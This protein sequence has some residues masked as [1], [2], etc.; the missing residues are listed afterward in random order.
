MNFD[1]TRTSIT[2]N[3][4]SNSN[5]DIGKKLVRLREL[6]KYVKDKLT[7]EH[8]KSKHQYN[9]RHRPHSFEVNDYV[10]VKNHALSSSAKDF[11]A[12]LGNKFCGPYKIS[13][14]LG[15]NT[16]ELVDDSN[17]LKGVWHVSQL[18]PDKTLD[19]DKSSV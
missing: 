13:K 14:K 18:K 2:D 8:E 15:V 6:R 3:G 19:S 10:W 1:R 11:S 16:Y 12:K 17:K 5:F 7:L 4:E 9:L